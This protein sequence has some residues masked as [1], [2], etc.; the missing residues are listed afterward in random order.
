MN[1][2]SAVLDLK[3]RYQGMFAG[4]LAAGPVLRRNRGRK[5]RIDGSVRPLGGASGPAR[6]LILE[7]RYG[8]ISSSGFYS[9]SQ[10]PGPAETGSHK[11]E[12]EPADG[13]SA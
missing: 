11:R 8:A 5:G 6:L 9:R 4:R 1:R 12:A 10:V 2:L 13:E 7:G 3:K